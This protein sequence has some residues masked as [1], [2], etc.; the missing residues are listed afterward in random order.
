MLVLIKTATGKT[1]GSAGTHCFVCV[2]NACVGVIL[3]YIAGILFSVCV[4]EHCEHV[5]SAGVSGTDG[6]HCAMT[7]VYQQHPSE[8]VAEDHTHIE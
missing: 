6:E 8:K 3:S 4:C 5:Y 1:D 2:R 7:D